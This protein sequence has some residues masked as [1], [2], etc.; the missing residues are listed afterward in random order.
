ME[1]LLLRFLHCQGVSLKGGRSE[2]LEDIKEAI[3]VYIESL[4]AHDE[5]VPTSI[6][7]E[8]VEVAV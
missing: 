3:E 6:D 1:C 4:K 7:E 2:A 5:L 8:V